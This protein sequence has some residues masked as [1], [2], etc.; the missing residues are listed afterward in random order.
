MLMLLDLEYFENPWSRQ[1]ISPNHFYS[2]DATWFS[3]WGELQEI[4]SPGLQGFDSLRLLA[5]E[6]WPSQAAANLYKK[7]IF[8]LIFYFWLSLVF[9]AGQ[10]L[11]LVAMNA[12]FSSVVILRAWALGTRASVVAACGRAESCGAPVQLP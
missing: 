10:V 5:Q 3:H 2:F 1:T 7:I 8:N 4:W 9:L 6:L 12:G 11:S